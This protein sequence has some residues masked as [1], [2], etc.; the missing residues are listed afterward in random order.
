MR[1][2]TVLRPPTPH[3]GDVHNNRLE[4]AEPGRFFVF[5]PVTPGQILVLGGADP[6]LPFLKSLQPL[7]IRR[8]CVV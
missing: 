8:M 7:N 4:S 2:K 1:R 6:L 3:P 5:A